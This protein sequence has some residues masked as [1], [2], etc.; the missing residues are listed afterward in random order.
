MARP[1][2]DGKGRIGGRQKGTPNKRTFDAR[3]LAEKIGVDPLEV[4]LMA[5]K[6]DWK[7]LGY[8]SS[9]TKKLSNTGAAIKVDTIDPYL[10]IQ[11]AKEAAKF[12]YPS[13][14]AIEI[15]GSETNPLEF[16][17]MMDSDERMKR[18][19]DIQK[20]IKKPKTK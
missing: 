10:Q 13:L 17:L 19:K 4:L 18:L 20:R 14:K 5:A 9:F 2:G 6:R 12:L 15:K 8:K 11:A 1:K 16:Y 3:A 7:G